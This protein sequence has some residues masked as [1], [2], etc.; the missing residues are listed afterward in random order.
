MGNVPCF[1]FGMVVVMKGEAQ[2]RPTINATLPIPKT[3]YNGI[4][5]KKHARSY[6]HFKYVAKGVDL[7][8]CVVCLQ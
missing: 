6:D 7:F 3:R 4:E 8:L 5:P 1:G 2:K